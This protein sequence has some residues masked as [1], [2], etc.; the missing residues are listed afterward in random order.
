[1]EERRPGIAKWKMVSL[2]IGGVVALGLGGIVVRFQSL[3]SERDKLSE[4]LDAAIASH[5]ER[6][7]SGKVWSP[8]ALRGES[9]DGNGATLQRAALSAL[10]A[11]EALF[12]KKGRCE[13]PTADAIAW[14]V[15]HREALETLRAASRAKTAFASFNLAQGETAPLP[16]L[17]GLSSAHEALLVM[18]ASSPPEECLAIAADAVRLAQQ[19]APG[20]GLVGTMLAALRQSEAARAMVGC[21]V[22]APPAALIRSAH[23]LAVLAEDAP[24]AGAGDT[25]EVEYLWLAAATRSSLLLSDGFPRTRLDWEAI[26]TGDTVIEAWGVTLDHVEAAQRIGSL[27]YP[28]AATTWTAL[29]DSDHQ[30][31]NLLVS[32]AP[33]NDVYSK[34]DRESL[35]TLRAAAT[36]MAELAWRVRDGSDASPPPAALADPF[37]KGSLSVQREDGKA[38]RVW[39]VGANGTDDGGSGDDVVIENPE[40]R[41]L[42]PPPR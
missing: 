18:A 26:A 10:D 2:I 29:S 37:V 19:W 3:R 32:L 7:H 20:A 1:M 39:S 41:S 30:S 34:R 23:E 12:G 14:T 35:A 40:K 36:L 6:L 21:S 33:G 9:V 11:P 17:R 4:R 8:H 31:K 25:L 28:E 38:L 22:G 24:N 42:C 5:E 27:G 13:E 15:E 16:N